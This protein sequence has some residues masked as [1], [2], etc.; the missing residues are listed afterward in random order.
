MNT[1]Q[2][3]K[4][5]LNLSNSTV[6]E[7]RR[8]GIKIKINHKRKVSFIERGA[9]VS[10]LLPKYQILK[11]KGDGVQ[12]AVSPTG[13]ETEILVTH[14]NQDYVGRSFC[15]N[16]DNFCHRMGVKIALGKLINVGQL[17]KASKVVNPSNI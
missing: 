1:A 12:L 5:K 8:N 13:G 15:L 7:L 9:I 14:D 11:L 10:K 4:K 3:M 2:N 16:T 6:A 17:V